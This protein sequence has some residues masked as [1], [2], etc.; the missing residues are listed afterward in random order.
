MSAWQYMDSVPLERADRAEILSWWEPRHDE[1]MMDL[2]RRF[3]WH[4]YLEAPKVVE[5]QTTSRGFE[6]WRLNDPLCV[7]Y[8]WGGVLIQF[9]IARCS[10]L[11]MDAIIPPPRPKTCELCG[12]QFR[13]DDVPKWAYTRLGGRAALDFCEPCSRRA[14]QPKDVRGVRLPGFTEHV[15]IQQYAA[16]LARVAQIVPPQNF[17]EPPNCLAHF[18]RATRIELMRIAQKRP[19][20]EAVTRTHDSWFNV[21][22]ASGVVENGIKLGRG[23]KCVA[24]DG[25]LCLSLAEKTIDDWLHSNNIQHDRE[26]PYPETRMRG[27]FLVNGKIVEYFGMAGNAEYDHKIQRKRELAE[28]YSLTLV[29]I[30]PHHLATWHTTQNEIA[31]R[32]EVILRPR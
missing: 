22:L 26:P 25:H 1:L 14:F 21:L 8:S 10:K 9:I 7:E 12:A 20:P 24:L 32:L 19:T 18:D 28:K 4:Y 30:Y 16:E 5:A 15:A 17:F 2:M 29:E 23:V 13:E 11:G 3:D 6:Q 27:D 31:Q